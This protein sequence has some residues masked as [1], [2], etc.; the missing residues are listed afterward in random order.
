MCDHFYYTEKNNWNILMVLW[1]ITIHKLLLFLK[2]KW[3]T[4]LGIGIISNNLFWPVCICSHTNLSEQPELVNCRALHTAAE[5]ILYIETH[6]LWTLPCGSVPCLFI[7]NVTYVNTILPNMWEHS[8]IHFWHVKWFQLWWATPPGELGMAKMQLNSKQVC[9]FWGQVKVSGQTRWSVQSQRST[10]RYWP[11]VQ[12]GSL[13]L[14]AN[15]AGTGY[16]QKI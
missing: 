16:G 7:H 11:E 1:V 14:L 15:L 2:N 9:V 13:C 8:K 10:N 4:F 5:F 6:L 12:G 3:R